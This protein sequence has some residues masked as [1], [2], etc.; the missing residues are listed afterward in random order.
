[1][2]DEVTQGQTIAT[3]RDSSTM[4]LKVPFPADDAAGFYVGQ[5]AV[6]TLDGS[7]E[8]LSGTVKTISGSN[9]CS[10]AT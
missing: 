10:P 7:F 3:V 2:G 9:T 4:T 6:V 8:T 1:V 5:T